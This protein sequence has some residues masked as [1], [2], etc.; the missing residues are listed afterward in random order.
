MSIGPWS[1]QLASAGVEGQCDNPSL[2]AD[3]RFVAFRGGAASFTNSSSQIYARDSWSNSTVLVT[4]NCQGTGPCNMGCHNPVISADGRHVF[5]MSYATD[6]AP[7][8]FWKIP[9]SRE[10][11]LNLFRRD[12]QERTTVLVS[13]NRELTGG[14]SWNSGLA[15]PR[16]EFNITPDGN[17]AV[18]VSA[19]DL[20]YEDANGFIDLLVWRASGRRDSRPR[21]S[22]SREGSEI[23]VRWPAGATNFVPQSAPDLGGSP[24]MDLPFTGTSVRVQL[25]PPGHA[26]FRLKKQ[27]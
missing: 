11:G 8:E 2:S 1:S 26:F 17:L 21:L 23:V 6:L 7:G 5:F 13:Q 22:V 3:G 15:T 18:V 19:D 27:E 12:L 20:V 9:P 24:W 25:Q 14:G 16:G 10:S 4:V